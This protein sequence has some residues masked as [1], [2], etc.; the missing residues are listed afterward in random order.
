MPPTRGEAY[1][2]LTEA[3]GPDALA[4]HAL[5]FAHPTVIPGPRGILASMSI[6][7]S[8]ELACVESVAVAWPAGFPAE[9]AFA[10]AVP[11]GGWTLSVCA[12]AAAPLPGT[13]GTSFP[14][15]LSVSVTLSLRSFLI[16]AL[17]AADSPQP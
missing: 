1:D 11:P 9:L 4:E 3:T 10:T 7:A 6:R 2:A 16:L 15:D 17:A 8:I 13:P 12:T 14:S 5:A